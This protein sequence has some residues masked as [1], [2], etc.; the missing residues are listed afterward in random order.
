MGQTF[1]RLRDAG[2]IDKVTAKR[3][4][5][6]VGLPNLTVHNY[7]EVSWAIVFARVHRITT[8]ISG[9]AAVIRPTHRTG[10]TSGLHILVPGQSV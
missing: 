1:D 5:K 3:M 10:A 7:D 8:V 4:K 6:A 9:N 2:L